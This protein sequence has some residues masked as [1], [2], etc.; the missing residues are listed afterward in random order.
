MSTNLRHG[1]YHK[2]D[3]TAYS[4]EIDQALQDTPAPTN[5]HIA[6]KILT[7][8]ILQADK[9]HIPKGKI[10]TKQTPLPQAIRD[11]IQ[12]RNH[13]RKQNRHDPSIQQLNRVIDH[14]INTHKRNLWKEHLNQN[15]N[16][17]HNTHSLQDN[18]I[19]LK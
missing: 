1:N 6:N 4:Q 2:A 17:K 13:I 18:L 12:Q 16:N 15:W 7:G 9:H 11:K 3:W 10:K 5:I 19:T 8:L 14:E